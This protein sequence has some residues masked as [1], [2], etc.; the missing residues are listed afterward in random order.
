MQLFR[1]L[2]RDRSSAGAI[3]M[4]AALLFLLQGLVGGFAHGAM[5]AQANDPSQ[6]ICSLHGTDQSDGK[7]KPGTAKQ[8]E[9]CTAACRIFSIVSQ[10]ILPADGIAV[11][12]TA[13]ATVMLPTQAD[14]ARQP[15]RRWLLSQPRAPPVL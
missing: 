8:G 7:S 1:T 12:I 2:M 14:D 4:L 11:P 3:A 10:A 5:V 13:T 15:R 9:C 6:I